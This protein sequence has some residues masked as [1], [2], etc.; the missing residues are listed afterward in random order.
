[1]AKTRERGPG[2]RT[3]ADTAG[4]QT[5][6]ADAETGRAAAVAVRPAT[7]YTEKQQR[8][9][10]RQGLWRQARRRG[11]REDAAATTAVVV[12]A[13]AGIRSTK[14]LNRKKNEI[15]SESELNDQ[16]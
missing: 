11:A 2:P 10:V 12:A 3:T 16:V 4:Q 1:M 13:E 6:A 15:V 5:A 9:R 14:E 8:R 7:P